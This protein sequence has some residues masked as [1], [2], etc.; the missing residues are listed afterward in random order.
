[1]LDWADYP[2]EGDKGGSHGEIPALLSHYISY[3]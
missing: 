3:R 2:L 1:M